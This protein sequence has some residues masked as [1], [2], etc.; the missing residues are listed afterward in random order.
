LKL[1]L[2]FLGDGVSGYGRLEGRSA[3]KE[4][5]HLEALSGDADF[6]L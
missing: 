2:R 1:N 5:Q 3:E 6:P 4:L